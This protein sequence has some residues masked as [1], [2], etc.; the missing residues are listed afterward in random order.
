LLG[1]APVQRNAGAGLSEAAIGELFYDAPVAVHWM[2]IDGHTSKILAMSNNHCAGIFIKEESTSDNST[3]ETPL[4]KR[5]HRLLY[6][7]AD[8]KG[9]R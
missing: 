7:P 5:R 1:N 8:L 6:K 3:L 4:K 9:G 2:T